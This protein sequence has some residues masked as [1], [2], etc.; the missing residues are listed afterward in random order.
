MSTKRFNIVLRTGF[1]LGQKSH[2]S[3]GLT[4]RHIIVT[5]V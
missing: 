1:E 5:Y 4:L 3:V 2:D